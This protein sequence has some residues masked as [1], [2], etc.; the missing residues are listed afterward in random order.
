M[1]LTGSTRALITFVLG[2]KPGLPARMG[3]TLMVVGV[4]VM[5]VFPK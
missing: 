1:A 2:E 3:I 4:V 5:H